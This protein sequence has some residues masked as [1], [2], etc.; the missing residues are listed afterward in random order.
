MGL[1]LDLCRAFNAPRKLK[2]PKC[3][4]TTKTRFNDYDIECG[5]PF[6]KPGHIALDAYCEHCE[7]EFPWKATVVPEDKP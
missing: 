7:A 2:C 3:G 4:K 5:E 6:P 1:N